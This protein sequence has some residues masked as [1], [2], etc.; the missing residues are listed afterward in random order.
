MTSNVVFFFECFV[1]FLQL[2]ALQDRSSSNPSILEASS[3]VIVSA[4]NDT[5]ALLY[6]Q[7]K[8]SGAISRCKRQKHYR[9]GNSPNVNH[10]LKYIK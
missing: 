3:R 1:V 8:A 7:I 10:C 4:T 9:Y 6:E 2:A 5:S